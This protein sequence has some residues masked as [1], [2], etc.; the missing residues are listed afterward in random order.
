MTDATIEYGITGYASIFNKRD[1]AF[2]V[3]VPGAFQRSLARKPP[4][5]IKMLFE[6]DFQKILGTWSTI[7]EDVLGLK[8]S[9]TLHGH[10]RIA[11]ET[12]EK[13]AAGRLSGLSIGYKAVKCERLPDHTRL[14]TEVE[15]YE[16]S[17]VRIG[18]CPDARILSIANTVPGREYP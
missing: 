4:G 2:D 6:H 12:A 11:V 9:G 8:V 18:A 1:M 5:A 3:V 15:L 7:R 13:I 10:R 16:I 17:I 14:L